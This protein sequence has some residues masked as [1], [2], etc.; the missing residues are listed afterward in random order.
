[1]VWESNIW[2]YFL[3]N[4]GNTS[5]TNSPK[6][7]KRF[8]PC[9]DSCTT[10]ESRK[11]FWCFWCSLQN[12]FS[13]V[14]QFLKAR[15]YFGLEGAWIS[16]SQL[17]SAFARNR[18]SFEASLFLS[19]LL[20]PLKQM[21]VGQLLETAIL[22]EVWEKRTKAMYPFPMHLMLLPLVYPIFPG[23]RAALLL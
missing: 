5:T 3:K 23:E 8:S 12:V 18:C 17:L 4:V 16:V 13:S 15:Y 1:M 6:V 2:E 9:L 19:I 7:L 10:E 11:V 22:L 21:V 20:M 14:C